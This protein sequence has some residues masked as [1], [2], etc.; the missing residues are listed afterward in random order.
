M[1]TCLLLLACVAVAVSSGAQ[2]SRET[3][4][5]PRGGVVPALTVS[6]ATVPETVVFIHMREMLASPEKAMKLREELRKWRGFAH[7]RRRNVDGEWVKPAEF[8]RKRAVVAKFLAE[9][10]EELKSPGKT[11][12]EKNAA[13]AKANAKILQAAQTW[14]DPLTRTYLMGLA[15]LRA[16]KPDRAYAQSKECVKSAPFIAAFQQVHG[17]SQMKDRPLDASAALASAVRLK[18]DRDGVSLLRQ[19]IGKVPGTQ[20]NSAA[21]KQC[22]ETLRAAEAVAGSAARPVAVDVTKLSPPLPGKAAASTALGRLLPT[23]AFDRMTFRQAS[24][25]AVTPNMLLLDVA[26][27]DAAELYV[28]LGTDLYAPARI[29]RVTLP[30]K[31]TPLPL[32]LVTVDGY[33]FTPVACDKS[34]TFQDG[35]RVSGGGLGVLLEMGS[36]PRGIRGRL[37]VAAEGAVTFGGEL[38]PGEAATALLTS[39]GQLAGM[40]LGRTDIAVEHGGPATFVPLADL[41]PLL[42]QAR[43]SS[44]APSSKAPPPKPVTGQTFVVIGVMT[45]RFEN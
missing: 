14:Q 24:A 18:A 2:E 40:L 34:V 36:A 8:A 5:E 4:A 31:A 6:Q 32:M 16:G 22:Q 28:K 38:L 27:A 11:D 35:Q 33:T 26:L 13:Q 10:Q 41:L 37:G 25:V 19:A 17:A 1:R 45:E 20:I 42:D 44:A 23:P 12:A 15:N 30:A 29:R 7:E 39:E 43:K 3:G 9:A 21:F